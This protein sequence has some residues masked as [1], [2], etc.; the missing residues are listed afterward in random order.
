M[1][2]LKIAIATY[3]LTEALKDG[4]VGSDR[5]ALEHIQV[6][7]IILAMRRMVRGLEYDISEMA[8]TTYLC[9]RA[10]NKP[11]TAI[12][13][14]LTRNFHHRAMVYNV[15]S[16]IS[17]PKYLEGRKVAVNRGYT[18]TTGLWA[19]GILQSEYGVDL[20]SIAWYPTGD[21]HVQEYRSPSYVHD[22]LLGRDIAEVLTAGEVDAAVGDIRLDSPEIR[23][24]IPDAHDAGADYFR[25][26]GVYPINHTVVIRDSLLAERPWVA[27]ELFN[28]FK[29]SKE[30]YLGHLSA[31]D[32]LSP[33]D[34]AAIALGDV[35][36][37]DPY[38]FGVEANRKALEA[39]VRFAVDQGVIPRTVTPEALFASGT[40][41]LE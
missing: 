2:P 28:A 6:D 18:V 40:L 9:A 23:P 37:G 31:G 24:L 27:E 26:T 20:S 21:E 13:V 4:R 12:P 5:L 38:P 39:A 29:A 25:K 15:G 16:G 17:G 22:D 10:F 41:G 14:F 19:R 35:V 33:Q 3:G 30:T 1:L 34:K 8:F 32:A 11:F 36:G 7:P